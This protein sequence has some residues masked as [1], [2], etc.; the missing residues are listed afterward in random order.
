[1]KTISKN[2]LFFSILEHV[3]LRQSADQMSIVSVITAG[4]LILLSWVV[5]IAFA[6][7]VAFGLVKLNILNIWYSSPKFGLALFGLPALFGMLSTHYIGNKILKM[8]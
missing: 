3:G 6:F 7:G 5:A 2:I 4:I 8:V 1:M